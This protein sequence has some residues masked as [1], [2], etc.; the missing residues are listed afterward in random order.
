[1]LV[2]RG[3]WR[4][5]GEQ[6]NPPPT[7]RPLTGPGADQS[8]PAGNKAPLYCPSADELGGNSRP[9]SRR[10]ESDSSLCHAGVTT[11]GLRRLLF[12][13]TSGP[14]DAP[15]RPSADSGESL[16]WPLVG[17]LEG[18]NANLESPQ[19]PMGHITRFRANL[20]LSL[21]DQLLRCRSCDSHR[22]RKGVPG[23][24]CQVGGGNMCL[25]VE[26]SFRMSGLPSRADVSET[27]RF[28][29]LLMRWTAPARRHLGAKMVV[30]ENHRE[31]GAVYERGY[32]DRC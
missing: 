32:H 2:G 13:R 11:R 24:A 31:T 1:M 17:G 30:F 12:T 4:S 25:E 15:V 3:P 19:S 28:R 27:G 14:Q 29:L 22:I 6:I 5:G 16:E 18:A 26:P 23:G 10:M 20:V 9:L 21:A 8:G 7:S